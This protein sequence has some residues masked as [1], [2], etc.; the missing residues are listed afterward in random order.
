MIT[1]ERK[2][3]WKYRDLIINQIKDE[4]NPNA[5]DLQKMIQRLNKSTSDELERTYQAFE[6]FGVKVIMEQ[7][8]Q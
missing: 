4:L 2:D 5:E 7:I 8:C 1:G 3:G 6:R